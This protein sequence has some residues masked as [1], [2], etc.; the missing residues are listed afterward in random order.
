MLKADFRTRFELSDHHGEKPFVRY[1]ERLRLR[2]GW[3]VTEL[4]ISP[5]CHDEVFLSGRE[6]RANV[7]DLNR[8]QAGVSL[9]P[10]PRQPEL[11]CNL[12]YM[13]QHSLSFGGH[14]WRATHI[15][16]LELSYSF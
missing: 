12:Y 15:Y 14:D 3:S 5:Y 4:K 7:F 8:F 16:G 11:S 1:R 9:K 10:L 2:T 13:L 6:G